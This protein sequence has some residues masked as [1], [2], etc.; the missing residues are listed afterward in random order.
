MKKIIEKLS[1]KLGAVKSGALRCCEKMKTMNKKRVLL[2]VGLVL[3]V[4]VL[5]IGS[6]G[7]WAY[8][9]ADDSQ[10]V[11]VIARILPYPALIVDGKFIRLSDWQTEYQGWEKGTEAQG[12]QVDEAQLKQDVLDK[13]LYDSVLKKLAKKYKIKITDE[14]LAEEVDYIVENNFDS[15]EQFFSQME[16]MF[17]W[18]EKTFVD[19]I[20][21]PSVLA[22][23]VGKKFNEDPKIW[24][25]AEERK[26]LVQER[27]AAGDL[28]EDLVMEFSD[29]EYTLDNGGD[30]GWFSRGEMVQEFED[31]A[32]ALNPGEVS[33]VVK[34]VY[35]YHFVK[36]EDK[37][38][39]T[40]EDGTQV[41]QV[42]AKHI[43]IQPENFQDYLE[44][45]MAD[46]HVIYL[47]KI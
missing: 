38:T 15:R 33:A 2:L 20:I 5:L 6:F 24:E 40:Q 36:L 16:E 31:A 46:L 9:H 14:R 43:L 7:L 29:D 44:E 37:Q 32:F 23:E 45:L 18:E 30:L 19:R 41:E 17:G 28:F 42:K 8:N 3:M 12:T 39:I 34:T 11:R 35:G 25:K 10:S 4:L 27:L 13:M 47:I 26:L 22:Q 21:Y 1:P